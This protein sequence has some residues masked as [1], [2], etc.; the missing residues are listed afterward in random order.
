LGNVGPDVLYH[1]PDNGSPTPIRANG[2]NRLIF[3]T[4]DT[5]KQTNWDNVVNLVT[6]L[7]RLVDGPDS[8][9]ARAQID[10]TA[11]K[12]RVKIQPDGATNAT[13]TVG[14]GPSPSAV[15]VNPVTSKV[16]VVNWTNGNVTVIDGETRRPSVQI[17]MIDE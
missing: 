13:T 5:T 11:E 4:V 14:T 10:D 7:A 8:Q 17:E 2:R 3:L 1:T 12:V 6:V 15:A 9:A 16:Y